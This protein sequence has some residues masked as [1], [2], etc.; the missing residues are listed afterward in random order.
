MTEDLVVLGLR[1]VP[2]HGP[3]SPRCP[4]DCLAPV[5]SLTSF[6]TLARAYDAPF[7][8]PRTVGDVLSLYTEGELRKI[9]GLGRRRISEIE[10]ALVLAG[11]DITGP[12]QAKAHP[13]TPCPGAPGVSPAGGD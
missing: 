12:A 2:H 9:H 13:V 6:N 4:I 1:D 3:V 11:L 10:A 5:L 8:P 7:D